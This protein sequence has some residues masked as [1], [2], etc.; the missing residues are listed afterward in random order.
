MWHRDNRV[1]GVAVAGGYLSDNAPARAMLDRFGAP[2]EHDETGIDHGDRPAR[3][4]DLTRAARELRQIAGVAR[5]VVE[6]FG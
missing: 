3:A 4:G 6:A 1:V 2:W 5:Q